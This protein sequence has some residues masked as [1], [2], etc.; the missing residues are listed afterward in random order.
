MQKK[1]ISNGL[2][3]VLFLFVLLLC[4]NCS[5]T[6]GYSY[7]KVN[8]SS[9][10]LSQGDL[11]QAPGTTW[12]PSKKNTIP[13]TMNPQVKKWVNLFNGSLR[14][15]FKLWVKRIGYYGPT[16]S[17]VLSEENVPQDI[18]YLAMIE[19]G[20]N[21]SAHSS[22]SAVGTWQFISSTGKM[23]GLQNGFFTD[24]R[25]DLIQSTKAAARHLNDLYKLYGDWYLAFAAYNA[26]SGKVNRAIKQAR[27]K[28]YW[29]LASSR[30]HYLRQ[31][32]KDYVP[33]ILAALH[34]V[35]NYSSF[36]YTSSDFDTP[37]QYDRVT[38]PD[39]TDIKAIAKSA[40]TTPKV[41]AAMNPS[42]VLG[43][44]PPGPSSIYVPKGAASEF[45]RNYAMIP[46]SK[47]VT[48]LQYKTGAHESL[49]GI[50][51][52]YGLSATKLAKLNNI[53]PARSNR[54][55][56]KGTLINMPGDQ[57]TLNSIAK[58]SASA[59]AS[60]GKPRIQT[61]TVYYKVRAG[62]TLSKIAKRNKTSARKLAQWNGMRSSSPLK[63]GQKIKLQNATYTAPANGGFLAKFTPEPESQERLSGVSHII[64]QETQG[65]NQFIPSEPEEI[66]I[67][68]LAAAEDSFAPQEDPLLPAF[69]KTMDGEVLAYGKK[70]E[71]E[72]DLV[73]K[74]EPTRYHV[75]LPGETLLSIASKYKM[76]VEGI[77][78]LNN[79]ESNLIRSN[80]KI[81]VSQPSQ[82]QMASAQKTDRKA[83]TKTA[84]TVK[85]GDT[86]SVIAKRNHVSVDKLKAWNNMTGNTIQ[87][88]Q[89]ILVQNAEQKT[90]SRPVA[91]NDKKVIYHK[92]Q[93][94]ETLW[95]L[96]RKYDV[97]IS[98][99]MKWNALNTQ[100]VKTNQKIKIIA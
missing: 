25:R 82:K 46:V 61:K 70:L 41:I 23:Y 77:K 53:Q 28:N 59:I 81:I 31:E 50:A 21:T 96:S 76:T 100:T 67:P 55:L 69:V 89:K 1:T 19:S 72:E 84:Y 43:I 58:L 63:I 33:K 49:T 85:S 92:V 87:P 37:M 14:S 79:L 8:S 73:Q 32:T 74:P 17:S 42:L 40:R 83:T 45:E 57:H 48:S 80:Q 20:F 4:A 9:N 26:G 54:E 29:T 97:K 11:A 12:R 91:Q 51:K 90:S 99:I 5:H 3:I 47:R 94:G 68:N 78:Q 13:V 15:S 93:A 6:S 60:S 24:D 44:T 64:V 2:G 56:K 65:G 18:I 88:G 30:H 95:S 62:D 86:L 16:I 10:R 35:K 34:I 66:E 7:H 22:A 71:E 36:G 39:A 75:V 38:V 98:D 27:S 52:K